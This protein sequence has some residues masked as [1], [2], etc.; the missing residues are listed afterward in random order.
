M[1]AAAPRR[2]GRE[3]IR[4][5]WQSAVDGGLTD[6]VLRTGAVEELGPDAAVEEGVLEAALGG[7]PLAGKYLVHWR[8]ADGAWKLHRDIWNWDS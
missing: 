4:G 8:R 3:A 1:P 7:T 5:F 2:D 6:V